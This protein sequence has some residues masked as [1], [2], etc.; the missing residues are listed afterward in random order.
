MRGL[1]AYADEYIQESD[2]KDISL[3]KMCLA[4]FGTMVGLSIKKKN[5]KIAMIVA[6]CIFIVTYIPLMCRFIHIVLRGE[7]TDEFD[8]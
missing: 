4:A 8:E 7:S 6:G 1:F 5:K 3:L 2:W